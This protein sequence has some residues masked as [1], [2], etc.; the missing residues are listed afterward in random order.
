VLAA[1][2]LAIRAGFDYLP[3]PTPDPDDHLR[4]VQLDG[5]KVRS[6]FAEARTWAGSA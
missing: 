4:R 5:D 6:V 1:W 3:G 2:G